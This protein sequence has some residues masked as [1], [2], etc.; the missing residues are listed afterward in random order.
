MLLFRD[1]Q[2]YFH[3]YAAIETSN[4]CG[5]CYK[6]LRT[7]DVIIRHTTDH[8]VHWPLEA[9]HR[10][11]QFLGR[12]VRTDRCTEWRK[13]NL[14]TSK[15]A[16]QTIMYHVNSEYL[17]LGF[18]NM[19]IHVTTSLSKQH[20]KVSTIQQQQQQQQ[21]LLYGPLS[22]TT[23]YQKKHSPTHQPDH[24]PIFISF[25]QLLRSTASSLIKLRA[26]QSICTTSLHV[27][28]GLP[29]SLE[30]STSYSIHFFT[31]SVSSFRNRCPYLRN[32]FAVV[33]K[34]YDLF[35]VFFS[36]PYSELYLSFTLTLHIHLTI[37]I[38][39]RWSATSSSFL[40]GQVSL[41]CSI[42]LH[43]QLLYSLP[44]RINDISLLVSSG[45]S[46]QNL[47][48]PIR[49]LASTAASASPSTLNI[50]P[51]SIT[52][53]LPPDLHWHHLL[54]YDLY[55]LHDSSNLYK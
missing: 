36:T 11:I 30:P 25:F 53:P 54:L 20:N 8:V 47:F 28:F 24:H 34:L 16:N 41:P 33:L 22:G 38:S 51:V 45:T 26:W 40:T 44:L 2:I 37:L 27:L 50:S 29:L 15:T 13:I 55:W 42:L 1:H 17:Q 49:I 46:C 3:T 12:R 43:T 21:Q 52:Y 6:V 32:L 35:L 7:D 31:Q 19:H 18:T 39:A 14:H 4:L 48:H 5:K 9:A 10:T 23:R